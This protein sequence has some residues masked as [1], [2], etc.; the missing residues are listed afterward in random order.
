[1]RTDVGGGAT[2]TVIMGETMQHLSALMERPDMKLDIALPW[3][4]SE[5][6]K[7]STDLYT[8]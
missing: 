6:V 5:C 3:V 4:L 1:M 7:A 8:C 2:A